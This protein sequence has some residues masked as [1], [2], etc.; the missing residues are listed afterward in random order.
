MNTVRLSV[1]GNAVN[2]VSD[3]KGIDEVI[4]AFARQVREAVLVDGR[5]YSLNLSFS[6][7]EVRD[8]GGLVQVPEGSLN[9]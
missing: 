3:N 1:S 7:Y 9:F 8:T 6:A 4:D 5:E 2:T